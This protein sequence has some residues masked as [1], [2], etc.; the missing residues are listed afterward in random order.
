MDH[1]YERNIYGKLFFT[2]INTGQFHHIESLYHI[3]YNF[4]HLYSKWDSIESTVNRKKKKVLIMG[5]SWN[6]SI[7]FLFSSYEMYPPAVKKTPLW[8]QSLVIMAA[9]SL[10]ALML[11]PAVGGWDGVEGAGGGRLSP[12]AWI[13]GVAAGRRFGFQSVTDTEYASF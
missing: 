9:L 11:R 8:T 6:A 3:C 1:P 2:F 5:K 7:I 13:T 10:F 12:S 4:I